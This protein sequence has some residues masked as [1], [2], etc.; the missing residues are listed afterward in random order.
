[1]PIYGATYSVHLEPLRI[2]QKKAI[3]IISGAGY[4]DHTT[5][6]FYSNKILKI[7]DLYKH[8]LGCYIYNNQHLLIE[9]SRSHRYDTRGSNSLL[10]PRAELRSTEQSV[11]YNGLKIW[12]SLPNDIKI[13]STLSSF[14][15]NYK[16]FLINQ[17]A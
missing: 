2:L 4:L 17:Y 1:M 9:H 12:D 8:S 13:C 10:L 6:L 3:R 11:I 14:K 7:D 16:N 15:Y 5:P